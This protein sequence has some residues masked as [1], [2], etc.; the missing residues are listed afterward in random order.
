ML[1]GVGEPKL[2]VSRPAEYLTTMSIMHVYAY[3]N[4]AQLKMSCL[5]ILKLIGLLTH[6][7]VDINYCELGVSGQIINQ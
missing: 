3:C 7:S 4:E 1:G 5:L 6:L 2:K